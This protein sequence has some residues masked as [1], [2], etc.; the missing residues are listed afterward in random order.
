MTLEADLILIEPLL[1][2][3][4]DL[5]TEDTEYFWNAKLFYC[6]ILRKLCN[7]AFLPQS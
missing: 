3:L 4:K 6:I 2:P 5:E 7:I 1:Q